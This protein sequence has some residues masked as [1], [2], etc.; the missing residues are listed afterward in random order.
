LFSNWRLQART[1]VLLGGVAAVVLISIVT[2]L[3]VQ[4]RANTQAEAFDK[5]GQIARSMSNTFCVDLTEAMAATR[6]MAKETEAVLTREISTDRASTTRSLQA[7]LDSDPFFYGVW[8]QIEPNL[9]DGRDAEY[10]G[11]EGYASDGGFMPYVQRLNGR[12]DIT[13][14][15]GTWD[16]YKVQ[17]YYTVPFEKRAE[18]V[19][20]PYIEPD[21]GN[22]MMTSTCAPIFLHGRPCGVVGI[23]LVLSDFNRRILEFKPYDTGYAFLVSNGGT[24]VAHPQADLTGKGLAD[25]TFS[26]ATLQAIAAGRE[27]A[28]IRR[29]GKGNEEVYVKFVPMQ[30][31]ETDTPWSFALVVPMEKILAGSTALTR[32]MIAIG[33]IGLL[34][35]LGSL[36]LIVRSIARPLQ[37]AIVDLEG[38]A[39]EMTRSSAEVS[40]SGMRLASAASTQAASLEEISSSL[41]SITT[42]TTESADRAR[43]A[44][45]LA[46]L[47]SE[48]ARQ[49]SGS[50]DR[51]TV[52]MKKIKGTSDQTARIIKT[53]DEIAF[54]TNLL[55]LNAAVEAARAGES[56]KGF[57]VVAEE[58]RTLAMR[59]ADAAR[60]T[61]ELIAEAQSNA[62]AGVIASEEVDAVLHRIGERIEHVSGLMSEVSD[63]SVEQSQGIE[64]IHQ[65]V[66]QLE[67]TTQ[68]TAATA[69]ESAASGSSMAQHSGLLRGIVSDLSQLVEGERAVREGT[70]P[71]STTP[72]GEASPRSTRWDGTRKGPEA[73]RRAA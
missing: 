34:A 2:F 16:E 44:N 62:D 45:R 17:P 18:C 65:G 6:S 39:G 20:E 13:L 70:R 11:K 42:R 3:A 33:C 64:H 63:A 56:G 59:S 50:M 71:V 67:Q 54:Q 49:G 47:A 68:G 28:E 7:V 66:S 24:V 51:M 72:A 1:L 5:S 29:M 25:L 57:A 22:V 8:F 23:D 14:S 32:T 10:A 52:A 4:V 36:W 73:I 12:T 69:Q 21:A 35:L 27:T 38:C 37:R 31:G 9:F 15:T 19:M 60:S 61:A 55:A 40:N 43:E 48:E 46:K 26:P 41:A 30:I 53:I 58:V